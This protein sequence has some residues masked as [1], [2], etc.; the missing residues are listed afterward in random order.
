MITELLLLFG[1]A[2]AGAAE[3]EYV[4]KLW[5]PPAEFPPTLSDI[6]CRLPMA[7]P[8][9][10]AD[11][12][13][14]AHEGSHF[15]SKWHKGGHA[16]YA[17]NGLRIILP[18][19]PIL[20]ARVFAAVPQAERGRVYETYRQQGE[21]EYWVAQPLM[22]VDEWVAY[23]HGS[24]A[25]RELGIPTRQESDRYCAEM[26]TYVWHLH[27]LA[28]AKPEYPIAELTAFCRWNEERCRIFIPEWRT[29]F[30]KT[31]D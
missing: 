31:F 13:T 9:K 6:A 11:L 27:R 28:K 30:N 29:M 8:A 10:D 21:S 22:L 16:V 25:R 20:T 24:L 26:G 4:A 3:L 18:T 2:T 17:G 5:S 15:L 14:Y 1:E 7:T 12:I 19:P 23:T